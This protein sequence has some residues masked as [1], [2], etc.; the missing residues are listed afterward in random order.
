MLRLRL[1]EGIEIDRLANIDVMVDG[2][3]LTVADER[4]T[5]TLKGRLLADHVIRSVT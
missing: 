2:G 4:A 3:L 1:R 5:L